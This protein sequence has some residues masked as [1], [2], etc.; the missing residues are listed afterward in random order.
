MS[1]IYLV[2]LKRTKKNFGELNLRQTRKY[3]R[4]KNGTQK[5]HNNFL[6]SAGKL[7]ARDWSFFIQAVVL[8]T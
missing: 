8:L 3:S 7:W 6:E 2:E 5:L 1:N 4:D